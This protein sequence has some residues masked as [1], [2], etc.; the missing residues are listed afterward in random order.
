MRGPFQIAAR[1]VQQ[2]AVVPGP[3]HAR[4][5][6][7]WPA[8]SW[9]AGQVEAGP[10]PGAPRRC[11]CGCRPSAGPAR[12]RGRRRTGPRPAVRSRPARCPGSRG[13]PARRAGTRWPGAGGPGRPRCGRAGAAAPPAGPVTSVWSGTA[14]RMRLYKVRAHRRGGLSRCIRTAS[15]HRLVEAHLGLRP[16]G[17]VAAATSAASSASVGQLVRGGRMGLLMACS[18]R[19]ERASER[20]AE[21]CCRPRRSRRARSACLPSAGSGIRG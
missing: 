4:G 18:D 11:C 16:G 5:R 15:F 19:W 8:G 14:S 10:A 20:V 13:R 2:S 12:Q 6:C 9:T 21:T 1:V 7:R 3:A 17:S